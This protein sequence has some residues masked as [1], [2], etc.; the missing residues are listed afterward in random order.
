M[1]FYGFFVTVKNHDFSE[2]FRPYWKRDESYV[3][4]DDAKSSSLPPL[5]FPKWFAAVG[6]VSRVH[7]YENLDFSNFWPT[8]NPYLNKRMSFVIIWML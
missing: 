3:A 6:I 8:F 1:P 5:R 7:N 4:F 2:L